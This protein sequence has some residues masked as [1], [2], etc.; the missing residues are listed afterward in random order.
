MA[1]VL[2]ANLTGD[3][4]PLVM[5][6]PVQLQQ[7]IL[8]L[9]MNAMEAMGH[10]G[11]E[12]R[13][14]RLRTEPGLA[15]TIVIRVVDSGPQRRSRSRQKNVSAVFHNEIGRNGNGTCNLQDD[16]EAHGGPLTASANKLAEWNFRSLCRFISKLGCPCMSLIGNRLMSAF[17][18]KQTWAVARAMSAF[19][20]KADMAIALRNVR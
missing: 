18:T 16:F 13:V 20:G 9:M 2:D 14:L 12:M 4:L 7:V 11:D 3:V 5:A 8:N 17:G 1:S 19:G 15:G 10:S 6:D